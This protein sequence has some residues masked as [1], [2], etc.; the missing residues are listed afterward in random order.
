[1][2]HDF[3]AF[4]ELTNR[5][6]QFYYFES[7]HKQIGQNFTAKV[8]EVHDGDTVTVRWDERNFDF[9]VRLAKINAPEL[10]NGGRESKEW[11]K[12]QIENEEVEIMINPFNRVGKFGRIIGT[13]IVGGININQMSKDFGFSNT[14]GEIS[15]I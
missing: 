15:V 4:P 8:I 1:M 9:P 12:E 11:L 13:I 10:N 2:A 7:P 3:K 5:Q 14:F 6:M